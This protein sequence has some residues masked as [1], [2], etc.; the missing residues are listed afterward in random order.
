MKTIILAGGCFWG[1]EAYFSRIKG[2]LDTT[3][4]YTD[5]D[6]ENPSYQE[7]CQSSGHVEAVKVVFDEKQ[8]SVP[9]ILDHFFRFVDPTAFNRQGHDIGVQYRS[10]IFYTDEDDCSII[11]HYLSEL[12]KKYTKKIY[13]YVKQATPFYDAETYH[14]DY[15]FKN[16]TGYCHV[17]LSLLRKNELKEE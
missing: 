13:T 6:S 15:L 7:V 4:G 12:Q 3:V 8:L 10:A 14:Q 5:G 1:V 2:V 17:D 16:P 11:E 9:S